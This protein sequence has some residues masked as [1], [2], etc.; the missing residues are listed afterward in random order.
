MESVSTTETEE[1]SLVPY[2]GD[3]PIDVAAFQSAKMLDLGILPRVGKVKA[4]STLDDLLATLWLG[5]VHE[6]VL[7]DQLAEPD[8]GVEGKDTATRVAKRAGVSRRWVYYAADLW[9]GYRC[10]KGWRVR[11]RK[12]WKAPSIDMELLREWVEQYGSVARIRKAVGRDADGKAKAKKTPTGPTPIPVAKADETLSRL[13]LGIEAIPP[14]E[15]IDWA[16]KDALEALKAR[17]VALAGQVEQVLTHAF[18][19]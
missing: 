1:T 4:K 10:A 7:C 18:P 12:V 3:H 15:A 13:A 5:Y 9:R 17:L 19:A 16:T 6:A 14:G 11:P 2:Q 8:D